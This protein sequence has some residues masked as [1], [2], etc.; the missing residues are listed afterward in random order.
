MFRLN[1]FEFD[2]V[3]ME[4]TNRKQHMERKMLIRNISYMERELS[5]M[6]KELAYL[7]ARWEQQEQP[8]TQNEVVPTDE[9]Q[10][11]GWNKIVWKNIVRTIR[12]DETGITPYCCISRKQRLRHRI[13][14]G[15]EVIV[16]IEQKLVKADRLYS[17][18]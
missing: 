8:N 6:K 16:D 9:Y 1:L 18:W 10:A 11:S 7:D 4:S 15:S 12:S 2:I 5:E 17:H 14:S 13:D 3:I